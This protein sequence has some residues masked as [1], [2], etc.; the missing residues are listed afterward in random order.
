MKKSLAGVGTVLMLFVLAACSEV[1]FTLNGSE[2]SWAYSFVKYDGISYEL[3]DEEA[4]EE[5]VGELL[6][7]VKRNVVDMDT[8]VNYVE[9]DFD[10]NELNPGAKL[11]AMKESGDDEI[12]Y[13]RYGK[14]F[15]ARNTMMEE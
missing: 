2:A 13:E 9:T 5:E 6:G 11:F 15:I 7:E 1:P 3:T 8:V 4:A 12:I 14:Y 10:S